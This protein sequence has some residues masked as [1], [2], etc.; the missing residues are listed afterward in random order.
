MSLAAG[1]SQ[2]DEAAPASEGAR[3]L[4]PCTSQ[5]VQD[6]GHHATDRLLSET[7]PLI[8][9][10]TGAIT[11]DALGKLKSA[12][13]S[14]LAVVALSLLARLIGVDVDQLK[15]RLEAK[16][17]HLLSRIH[18][19]KFLRDDDDSANVS[20][21]HMLLQET[22]IAVRSTIPYLVYVFD[23]LSLIM[24]PFSLLSRTNL[25]EHS[26][27][28]ASVVSVGHLSTVELAATTIASVLINVTGFSIIQGFA[29]SLHTLQTK[30]ASTPVGLWSFRLAFVMAILIVV[31]SCSGLE[32]YNSQFKAAHLEYMVPRRRSL[33]IS[34]H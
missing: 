10:A 29:D 27:A 12:S 24:R 28:V 30:A 11:G 17:D 9:K 34:A 2:F 13:S 21:P 16:R 31:G 8:S 25:Q 4:G 19:P 5:H 20:G 23:A 6:V 33:A 18:E 26:I 7:T 32:I 14:G 3:P 1:P 15:Q 22:F